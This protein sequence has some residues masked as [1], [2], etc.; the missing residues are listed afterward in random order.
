MRKLVSVLVAAMMVFGCAA[1]SLAEDVENTGDVEAEDGALYFGAA[2]LE[3]AGVS[4]IVVGGAAAEAEVPAEAEEPE[5]VAV[6]VQPAAASQEEVLL[7]DGVEWTFPVSAAGLMDNY[8]MVVNADNPLPDPDYRPADLATVKSRMNDASGEN[9]NGGLNLASPGKMQL[10]G[11]ASN[12]LFKLFTAAEMD[13]IDL[14]L[15]GGW[16]S[17][18]DQQKRFARSS[19]EDAPGTSDFQT[20]LAALVVG[21]DFRGRDIDANAFSASAEGAWLAKNCARFGFIIR[22]PAGKESITGHAYAPA[23]LR[24]VGGEAAQYIMANG[25]CL[26]EFVEEKDAA[27]KDFDARGGNFAA[28]IAATYLP[29]GPLQLTTAGPDGD[30]EIVLFHD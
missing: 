25:L 1:V 6:A 5:V 2:D 30:F 3:A 15:R 19:S 28:A 7:V 8:Q 11:V 14:Y 4:G 20:G 22:Y 10:S 17:K 16:R 26:E 24:Y 12:A 13:H 9:T 23:H 29:E 27:I 18:A 21:Y